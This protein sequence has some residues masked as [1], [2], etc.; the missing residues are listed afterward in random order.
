LKSRSSSRCSNGSSYATE[1]GFFCR[2]L[3]GQS[4]D[5]FDDLRIRLSCPRSTTPLSL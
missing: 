1:K 5:N 4:G 2:L 3:K